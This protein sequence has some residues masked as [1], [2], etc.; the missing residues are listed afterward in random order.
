MTLQ[1]WT[2]SDDAG[3]VADD[4]TGSEP[5]R[6]AAREVC[7]VV[8]SYRSAC[9]LVVAFATLAMV[10][11]RADAQERK[12]GNRITYVLG[13][14]AQGAGGRTGTIN[15]VTLS[16]AIDRIDTD[17]SAH[18]IMSMTAPNIPKGITPS[19]EASLTPAGAIVTKINPNIKPHVGMS[20]AEAMALAENASAQAI[21]QNLQV[22]NAFADTCSARGGLKI[23][24]SWDAHVDFPAPAIVH[25]AVTGQ[26][27]KNGH[28]SFVITMQSATG[29]QGVLSGQGYYDPSVHLVS[30][31]HYELKSPD[32]QTTL[33]TDIALQP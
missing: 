20:D 27:P 1:C 9:A 18:A 8:M 14:P 15:Q 31:L 11:Q 25:Y 22:F 13:V 32:A 10:G 7:C 30:A 6:P 24:D 5:S 19:F 2:R 26:Q 4:A 23:G 17:G 33:T 16:L 28:D 29:S 3:T 12:P 21:G